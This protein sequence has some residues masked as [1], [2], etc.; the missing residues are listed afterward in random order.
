MRRPAIRSSM[1]PLPWASSPLRQVSGT[2]SWCGIFGP[3]S[4]SLGPPS[5]L[6]SAGCVEKLFGKPERA[7]LRGAERG[8]NGMRRVL[9]ATLYHQKHVIRTR[10]AI[11]QTVSK[12]LGSCTLAA[13]STAARGT[14]LRS[15]R[16]WCLEPGLPRS[17]G[18][19]PT[20]SPPFGGHARRVQARLR[21]VHHPGP[22][23][24]VQQR[25]VQATP[26]ARLL[27]IPE[28]SPTGY[29]AS[30]A[31]LLGQHPPR[32]AAPEDED[33]AREHGPLRYPRPTAR[34]FGR[35]GR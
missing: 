1:S 31:P 13:V 7:R 3:R 11:Y 26:D 10:P 14:P 29:T 20:A 34:G 5:C 4:N 19:G 8:Q 23:Q 24:P 32:D 28:P 25:P 35:F 6:Y 12:A 15:V 9:N 22:S 16:R 21:P 27:P 33:D 17:V 30:E 18:F 2:F